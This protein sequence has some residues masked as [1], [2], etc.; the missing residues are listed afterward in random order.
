LTD[1]LDIYRSA[2]LIID[3]Y[4]EDAAGHAAKMSDKMA[5][6][7][8]T[9]GYTMWELIRNAIDELQAREPAKDSTVH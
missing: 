6:K 8:D 1:D 3:Q 5:T 9:V 2:K 7:D 4:G